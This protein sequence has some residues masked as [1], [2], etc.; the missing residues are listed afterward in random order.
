[1]Q[2]SVDGSCAEVHDSLRGEGSFEGAVRGMGILRKH[3][4]PVSVRMTVHRGNVHDLRETAR[5]LIEEMELPG[6]STNSAG[7][8]GVCSRNTGDIALSAYE[9]QEAMRV[10][11]SLA[12]EYP[13]MITATAGPLADARIWSRMEEARRSGSPPFEEGGHLTGC[14]CHWS[15]LAVRSDGAFV[16]CSMLPHEVLGR[17]NSDP[18]E[19]VWKNHPVLN[20]MRSRHTVSLRNFEPCS[21]CQWVD[22]C[23]GNCPALAHSMTGDMNRPGP[24]AC[25]LEF[26]QSGGEVPSR[27]TGE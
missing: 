6:F 27:D 20:G 11:V 2:V 19:E 13:G 17:I 22:Y 23:T 21:G 14:G 8:I 4:I 7:S 5:F 15:T 26:V 16:P 12:S 25:L 18:L 10:L 9:R 1:V 24:D 3:G